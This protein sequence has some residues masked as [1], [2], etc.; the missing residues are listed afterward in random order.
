MRVEHARPRRDSPRPNEVDQRSHNDPFGDW[1]GQPTMD[2]Q[3]ALEAV[4]RPVPYAA[5]QLKPLALLQ[6]VPTS[7]AAT[8][9]GI[10]EAA[11]T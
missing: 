3:T 9:P 10:A 4:Q 2:L 7:R 5:E 1:N 6:R 8:R 11:G